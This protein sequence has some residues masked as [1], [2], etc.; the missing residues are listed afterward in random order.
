MP[1]VRD[2][3]QCSFTACRVGFRKCW[4]WVQ[5]HKPIVFVIQEQYNVLCLGLSGAGKSTLLAQLVDEPLTETEPTTGFNMKTL[6]VKNV[7][8]SIKEL[9]GSRKVQPFWD[10][11]FENKNAIVFVV[12][13]SSNEQELISARDVLKTVFTDARLKGKPC[14]IIG[15]HSDLD[16]AKKVEELETVFQPIMQSRKWRVY[17]CSA[18]ERIQVTGALEALI[19][20]MLINNN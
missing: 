1:G 4:Q 18:L 17:C 12:D 19:D 11:Y 8:I 5:C 9:G 16:C 7:V 2:T 14:L 15:T 20:L 13:A 10:H 6:P 3:L